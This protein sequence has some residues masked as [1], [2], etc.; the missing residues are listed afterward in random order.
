MSNEAHMGTGFSARELKDAMTFYDL[1]G[2]ADI[3]ELDDFRGDGIDDSGGHMLS[4]VAFGVDVFASD[5]GL[6]GNWCPA[7][8][9]GE[10]DFDGD[11]Y[12]YELANAA[13]EADLITEDELLEMGWDPFKS[14][15]KAVKSAVK[16]VQKPVNL[17][18][19]GVG[20]VT[21]TAAGVVK[22][23]PLVGGLAARGLRTAGSVTQAGLRLNPVALLTNPKAAIKAQLA[24]A[25]SVAGTAAASLKTAKQLV[26]SP[27]VRTVAAGAAIVFPPVG[28]PAAAALA[29]TAALTAALDSKAAGVRRAASTILQNTAKLAS[30]GK[31]AK[32]GSKQAQIG[33]GAELALYQIARESQARKADKL[34]KPPKG[35]KRIAY[36]VLPTG[37]IQRVAL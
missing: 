10:D 23:V 12:F 22:H 24:A 6:D 21:R 8:Q 11:D 28:I 3:D 37:R 36:D 31:R 17:I 5:D 14:I 25:K 1:P 4:R 13:L 16:V 15:K 26:K 32:P 18:S 9:F 35:A 7:A 34:G 29:T 2:Q 33:K 19:K 27:V 20:T 30:A